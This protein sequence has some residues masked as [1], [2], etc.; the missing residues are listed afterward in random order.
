MLS[1]IKQVVITPNAQDVHGSPICVEQYSFSPSNV[2][3]QMT[4]EDYILFVKYSLEYRS[5]V[6]EQISEQR[7]RAFLEARANSGDIVSE[8]PY[9]IIVHTCVI[10]D[11]DG[12]G[13]NSIYNK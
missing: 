7:E 8:E 3:S 4:V 11:L 9:G 10:R 5:M 6:V 12:L 2:L 13:V 1:L